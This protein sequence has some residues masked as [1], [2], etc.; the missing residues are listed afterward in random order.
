MDT[1]KLTPGL[2][3]TA[4]PIGNLR[5]ITFR[6][7]DAL[8][9][10]DL[11]LCEDTRQ[12]AKLCAA[13]DIK[14]ERAPY[15]DHNGAQMRP[16]ILARLSEG[17]AICLVSDAGTPLISD[18]GYKLV[19]QARAAGHIVVPLP[20][21]SAVT[22]ALCAAGVPSDRFLFVGF[23]P[24]KSGAR[25]KALIA[26][27]ETD[28]T[29]VFYEGASRL[30]DSL[31]QM[32]QILGDRDAVVAR[33]LTKQFEEFVPGNLTALAEHFTQKPPK[34]EIVILV[35]PPIKLI[36]DDEMIDARLRELLGEFR[37]KDA[38]NK[39]AEELGVA[40]KRAYDRALALKNEKD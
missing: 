5:D 34:G 29:L 37:S 28:A 12:T 7:V 4:T 1:T 33:E 9:G 15:H 22:T 18:P 10:A 35:H 38:A 36:A 11:I 13:Y 6:A 23:L 24:A 31:A 8:R 26:L 27:S 30:A 16:Q 14:T 3:I 20:G 40:K 25:E 2:Y 21:A 17:A 19:A 32:A 39:V